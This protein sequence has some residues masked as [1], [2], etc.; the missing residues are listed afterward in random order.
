MFCCLEDNTIIQCSVCGKSAEKTQNQ[1]SIEESKM[2]Y[3][4]RGDPIYCRKCLIEEK[5]R[6]KQELE[7]LRAIDNM[8]NKKKG[9]KVKIS[10]RTIKDGK[11]WKKSNSFIS[12]FQ[13][14][15]RAVEQVKRAE[16]RAQTKQEIHQNRKETFQYDLRKELEVRRKLA[17]IE[18]GESDMREGRRPRQRSSMF[19]SKKNKSA[20]R[21]QRRE[22][23]SLRGRRRRSSIIDFFKKF[24]KHGRRSSLEAKDGIE[25]D[26]QDI[27]TP[28]NSTNTSPRHS[29]HD[30]LST[31][32]ARLSQE[33]GVLG[34]NPE[35]P[36][37]DRGP[38]PPAFLI[39]TGAVWQT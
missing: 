28:V 8:K 34:E 26:E 10:L 16:K 22:E 17:R 1:L 38:T 9:S 2:W 25:V 39:L 33:G 3:V 29:E 37:K 32:E 18:V 12:A 35:I 14:S 6:L 4:K 19:G 7:T 20:P 15:Q 23:A 5:M 24:S 21:E 27:I 36:S 13:P 11:A 30:I 31:L